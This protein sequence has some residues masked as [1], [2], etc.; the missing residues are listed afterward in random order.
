[1][2]SQKW[3]HGAQVDQ[4]MPLGVFFLISEEKEL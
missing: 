2:S 3:F 4:E 1:V